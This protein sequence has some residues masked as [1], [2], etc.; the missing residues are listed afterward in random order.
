MS[1]IEMSEPRGWALRPV[2]MWYLKR[3]V[4]VLGKLLLGNPHNYRML[5]VYTERF[6]GCGPVVEVMR[7]AG[8]DAGLVSYFHGCATGVVARKPL[9]E[10]S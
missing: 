4:P 8:F 1:L 5:G 7:G 3:V 10:D 9:R 6:Q 2:F